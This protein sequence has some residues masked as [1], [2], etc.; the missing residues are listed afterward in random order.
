MLAHTRLSQ[1][2]LFA[3]LRHVPQWP[4]DASKL[5]DACYFSSAD[6]ATVIITPPRVTRNFD[7]P[8]WYTGFR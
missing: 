1:V 4:D 5:L 8:V 3:D 2:H 7:N 6:N